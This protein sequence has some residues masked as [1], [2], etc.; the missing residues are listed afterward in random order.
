MSV[1]WTIRTIAAVL[2]VTASTAQANLL[3]NA[4]FEANDFYGL[5]NIANQWGGEFNSS[6]VGSENGVT[7]FGSQMLRIGDAGGG[8]AAQVAQEVTGSF[9]AG[10]TVQFDVMLNAN[11][12]GATA[13]TRLWLGGSWG[14]TPFAETA[15]NLDGIGSTW[16]SL[17]L[18][19]VL[20]SD[21]TSIFA[22]IWA[23]IVNGGAVGHY[24]EY[25]NQYI[26]ADNTS[27]TVTPASVPAPSMLSLLLLG[28][29]TIGIRPKT[30]T[31]I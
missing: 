26:Y 14:I 2:L 19:A 13:Y 18:T 4:D 29:L 5:L 23:P 9:T 30:R 1:K 22:E 27:L 16:E 25:P 15:I 31:R 10:S 3:T 6:L 12:S 28:L 17:S 24:V 11:A 8:S 7:A 20:T 21:I